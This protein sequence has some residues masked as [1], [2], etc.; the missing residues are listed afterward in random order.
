MKKIISVLL[1]VWLVALMLLPGI[2]VAEA[3]AEFPELTR[4]ICNGDRRRFLTSM[5]NFYLSENTAVQNALKEGNSAVFLFDGCSDNM[6]DPKL[7]DLSY[8]RVSAV[9]IVLRLGDT[10]T[11]EIVYFNDA[12]S[13][14]PDRPLDYGQWQLEE[15]GDVGPATVCDGT[16]E[17]Y[18]VYHMGSYEALHMRTSYADQTAVAVYMTPE[19]YVTHPA[20]HINIHTRTGNHIL[21]EAAWSAGCMLVGD[22][23]FAEFE[24]LIDAAYYTSYE[25]FLVDQKVG[26]VTINRL[27][28]QDGMETLYEE[29]AAVHS[30]LTASRCED[31]RIYLA[32]CTEFTDFPQNRLVKAVQTV[33][34]MSL[35]CK[36][37]TDPRSIPAGKLRIG[38]KVDICGSVVNTEGEVWYEVELLG[39]NSYVSA[40][41]VEP[42]RLSL[43][44]RFL[45]SI[46]NRGE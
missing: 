23:D 7:S 10:G 44:D 21:Q 3:R 41:D 30:I 15:V 33:E 4:M 20:T 46:F 9:C 36:T 34:L 12:C 37:E 13:T 28:L 43:W 6:D 45:E 22:G 35:P 31:P 39:N 38:S 40:A 14:L 16:Y 42:T 1:S 8:Y 2:P 19:G 27:L 25:D 5:L 26:T 24:A 17:L 18:S 29:P 32:R 11:P